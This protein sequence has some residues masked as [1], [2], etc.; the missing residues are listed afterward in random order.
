MNLGFFAE[1]D[2]K[3]EQPTSKKRQDARK[4]GQVAKSP[5]VN[6]AFLFIAAFAALRMFA[7]Y[8]YNNLEDIF[9]FNFTL[10]PNIEDIFNETFMMSYLV[11]IFMRIII[12]VAP[13]LAIV[14][15]VGIVSNV[16]QVGFMVTT[17]PLNPK[18]SNLNPLKG[19]KRL[20]S[21]KSVVNLIKSLA[22][23]TIITI[24]IYM[25][26]SGEIENIPGLATLDLMHSILYLGSMAVDMGITI[27]VLFLFIAL[28]DVIYTR[29]SHT[30]ELK[31]TKQE[32][33]DEYKQTEGD[34][35]IKGKIKQK[36]MEVSM[37]RMMS[38][39][40][41]ADVVITNPTHYAVA[42]QY[43]KETSDAPRVVAKGADFLARKIK[44]KAI[45]N[46]V[47]I[48]QDRQL[49]RTIYATVNVGQTIPP[50][51]YKAVAEILAHVYKMRGM[52]G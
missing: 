10:M 4:K 29:F 19:V 40:P 17:E 25:M 21:V 38:D 2:E 8:L 7:G 26:I 31:M 13:L 36:M 51:L 1:K 9:T 35:T 28:A 42:I 14:L 30:K 23:M 37:R 52:T 48:V 47:P 43:D 49:A 44:D 12:T 20:F 5:E 3:T 41:K 15:L 24:A 18:L 27:G 16:I 34:P 33:K 32:V 50:E 39:I 6:T 22:K 11:W 46:N 45:E